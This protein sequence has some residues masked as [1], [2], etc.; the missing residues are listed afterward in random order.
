MKLTLSALSLAVLLTPTGFADGNKN[1]FDGVSYHGFDVD[2]TLPEAVRTKAELG[3]NQI[4]QGAPFRGVG[5]PLSTKQTLEEITAS[6]Q[7]TPGIIDTSD[8]WGKYVVYGQLPS[9]SNR[10]LV[11]IGPNKIPV[12]TLD[13]AIFPYKGTLAATSNCFMCH[14]TVVDNQIVAGALSTQVDQFSRYIKL[15]GILKAE[16][17]LVQA[18]QAAVDASLPGAEAS[19]EIFNS[20]A[21]HTSDNLLGIYSQARTRGDNL[22]PFVVWKVMSRIS[23]PGLLTADRGSITLLDNLWQGTQIPTAD[24]NPW[25]T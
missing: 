13:D 14:A 9:P 8:D 18:N 24:A 10:P 15:A 20:F 12:Q 11:A 22:G 19:F 25:G 1:S 23:G 17:A 2:Q 6:Q 4:Y 5:I 21:T 7:P 16:P 3:L